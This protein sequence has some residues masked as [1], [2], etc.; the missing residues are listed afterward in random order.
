MV[1]V[2]A[3]AIVSQA[4]PE[5]SNHDLV[6]TLSQK[7]AKIGSRSIYPV[8]AVL[9][10]VT[11]LGKKDKKVS[12]RVAT[13][14]ASPEANIAPVNT[15]ILVK[16][17]RLYSPTSSKKHT[18]FDAVVAVIAKQVHADAIFSFDKFYKSKG[19]KLI[20]DLKI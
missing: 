5:D 9:E 12:H 3:D 18:L 7:L 20:S 6:V 2:D 17:L 11:V 16:A 8:T 1:V 15:E 10:A 13:V 19:F 4:N 14:F